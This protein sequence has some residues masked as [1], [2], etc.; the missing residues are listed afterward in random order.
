MTTYF[1]S[2]TQQV[3]EGSGLVVSEHNKM[4]DILLP[5]C[6]G[7]GSW[8]FAIKYVPDKNHYILRDL[9][10]GTG[11]FIK[12]QKQTILKNGHIISYGDSHMVVG[13]VLEKNFKTESEAGVIIA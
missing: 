4:N 10:E 8:H 2:Y 5:K 12:V 9:G 7:F 1:G 13:I 6:E 3:F 11:T